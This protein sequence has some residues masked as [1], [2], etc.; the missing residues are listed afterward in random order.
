MGHVTLCRGLAWFKW[1]RAWVYGLPSAL[2]WQYL[3]IHWL[4]LSTDFHHPYAFGVHREPDMSLFSVIISPSVNDTIRYTNYRGASQGLLYTINRQILM[5]SGAGLMLLMLNDTSHTKTSG[6]R[7]MLL[8]S[9]HKI[10]PRPNGRLVPAENLV[11]SE[12]GILH[13][14]TTRQT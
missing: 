9:S 4:R 8:R 5:T 1:G 6:F 3:H 2:P 11:K 12:T 13:S 14:D 7:R 10:L